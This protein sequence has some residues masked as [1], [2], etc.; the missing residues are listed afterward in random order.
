MIL[1][2]LA[3]ILWDLGNGN[4][5]ADITLWT[6]SWSDAVTDT[7][8]SRVS[9]CPCSTSLHIQLFSTLALLTN[10]GPGPLPG[11]W[12]WTHK[13]NNLPCGL[14]HQ[15]PL[16]SPGLVEARSWLLRLTNWWHLW[17][18]SSHSR[19]FFPSSFHSCLRSHSY[20]QSLLQNTYW[21]STSLAESWLIDGICTVSGREWNLKNGNLELIIWF[22]RFNLTHGL[23]SSGKG[24]IGI[25]SRGVSGSYTNLLPKPI[26]NYNKIVEKL[27]W[28]NDWTLVGEKCY[29]HGQKKKPLHHNMTGRK[30]RGSTRGLAGL[31]WVAAKVLEGYFSSWGV[32]PEK[33]G[34]QTQTGLPRL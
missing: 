3:K 2:K 4:K 7:E 10:S 17:N 21:G 18:S 24:H 22:N 5:E 25:R 26:W 9:A 31:P 29:N 6:S 19:L 15:L 12:L 23:V 13:S 16:C 20:N 32:P 33:C 1:S 30:C 8:E 28:I 34:V 11:T 27:S 14:F